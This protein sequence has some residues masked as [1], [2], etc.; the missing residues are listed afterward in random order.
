MYCLDALKAGKSEDLQN[1]DVKDLL[2]DDF[3]WVR[4]IGEDYFG[5]PRDKTLG[6]PQGKKKI[7]FIIKM[8]VKIIKILQ[9]CFN[10]NTLSISYSFI[11]FFLY[12]S[13]LH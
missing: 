11:Q 9:N 6:T 13:S 2:V 1:A 5:P 3:D 12:S 10:N 4:H 8:Y 7:Q